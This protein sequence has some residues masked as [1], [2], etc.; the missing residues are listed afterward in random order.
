MAATNPKPAEPEF[1]EPPRP[2]LLAVRLMYAGA[3]LT[4]L[5]TAADIASV[6]S[7]VRASHPHATAAQLHASGSVLVVALVA[8]AL[9][10]IG[11]WI[12]LAR[13][14]RSGLGWARIAASVL[15]A[16][17][18]GYLAY[19][20]AGSGPVAGRA[21]T[22]LIWLAGAGAVFLLWRRASTDYF[23]A[24]TAPSPSG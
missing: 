23:S 13:A 15:C 20:L 6:G 1:L 12:F 3:A 16:V 17:Y 18:T 8:A 4:A 7:A 24:P 19:Q 2:L 5:G 14:N 21:V 22:A 11:I 10:E 9:L